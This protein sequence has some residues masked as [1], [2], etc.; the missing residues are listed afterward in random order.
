[1]KRL[2]VI[3]RERRQKGDGYKYSKSFKLDVARYYVTSDLTLCQVGEIF[4]VS[5][6]NVSTWVQEFS[7]DLS[8]EKIIAPMT[9]EEK[10]DMD[11]LVKQIEA[12]KKKAEYDGMKIFA[13]ET[14]VDLA[15]S[16]LG[17]DLRK[18]SGAKQ[19]KE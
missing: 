6:Q 12:L 11:A 19:P 14:M 10:K 18:N 4:N 2:N 1:M 15:K 13:L 7:S 17:I 16:E 8:A 3:K 9:E 5:H